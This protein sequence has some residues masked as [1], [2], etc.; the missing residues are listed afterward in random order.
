MKVT[1]SEYGKCFLQGF[2]DVAIVLVL[3]AAALI[4]FGAF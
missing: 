4:L 3:V 2:A 1:R